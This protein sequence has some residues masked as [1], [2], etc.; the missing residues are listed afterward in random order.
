MDISLRVASQS[1]GDNSNLTLGGSS[2]YSNSVF[3]FWFKFTVPSSICR[4]L[5]S[6]G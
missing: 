4:F 6:V 2:T 3:F 5:Q 1:G